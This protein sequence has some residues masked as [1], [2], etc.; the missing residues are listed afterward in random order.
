VGT[1]VRNVISFGIERE[2]AILAATLNPALSIGMQNRVGRIAK[3]C[4][5]DYLITDEGLN[6]KNVIINGRTI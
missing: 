6:I 4:A 1:E 2:K 3:G 5:A